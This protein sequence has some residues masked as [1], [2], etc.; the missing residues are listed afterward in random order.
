VPPIQDDQSSGFDN[1]KENFSNNIKDL[2]Y[3]RHKKVQ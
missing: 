2:L 3:T 1:K